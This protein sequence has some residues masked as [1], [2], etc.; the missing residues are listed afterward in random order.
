MLL[1]FLPECAIL[2]RM[3]IVHHGFAVCSR[4]SAVAKKVGIGELR[5]HVAPFVGYTV[6]GRPLQQDGLAFWFCLE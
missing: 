3:S 2:C 4:G 6:A 5:T 1:A